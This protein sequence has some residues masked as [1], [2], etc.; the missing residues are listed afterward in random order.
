MLL[1]SVQPSVVITIV[2]VVLAQYAVA[3]ACL[4]KLAYLDIDKKQYIWWNLL[5]LIIFFIGCGVFI[6]YYV[7]H[8]EKRLSANPTASED[9]TAE[10][11]E[12]EVFARDSVARAGEG[13][14]PQTREQP[15]EQSCEVSEADERE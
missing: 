3:T 8:P 5:I 6:V 4:L 9:Q 7:K 15:Q 11:P 10:S 2:A 14:A 1:S 13:E 12:R